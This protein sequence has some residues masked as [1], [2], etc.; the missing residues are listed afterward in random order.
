MSGFFLLN[1]KL[2]GLGFEKVRVRGLAEGVVG[3]G[4]LVSFCFENLRSEFLV[5]NRVGPVL[6]GGTWLSEGSSWR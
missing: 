5:K 1:E 6:R 4:L 2:P 3:R